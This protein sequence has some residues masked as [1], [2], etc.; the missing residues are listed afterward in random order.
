MAKFRE[1]KL[2]WILVGS[3]L[4]SIGTSFVWP[5]T[6]LYLH[7]TLGKSLTVIGI[8]LL[9]YSG[10]NVVGSYL[11]GL[12]FDKVN[13][14]LLIVGGIFVDVLAMTS[15]VFFNQWPAYPLLL[16]IVGFF[17]GWLTTLINSLGTLIRSKDGRYVFNMLYFASNLGLVIGT[18]IVGF[19][20]HGKVGIMFAITAV[21][22]LLY[23]AVAIKYYFVDTSSIREKGKTRQTKIKIKSANL[24]IMWSLFISLGIIWIMY[25]Q[26]VSNMSVYV[27]GQGVSMPLYSLLWTLN[28][29]LIVVMQMILNWLAHFIKNIFLQIY[30]GIFFCA[31][32]F[33]ILIFSHHYLAFVMAMV[34]LTVGE[35]TAF[36]SI[37]TIINELSPNELKGK[38]QGL[39]N[40]FSSI[41]KALGPLFGG[42]VIEN[43]SYIMLF[44][45]CAAAILLA[46]ILIGVVV[47]LKV[48]DAERY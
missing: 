44:V 14:R 3:F 36:P 5:L 41:G 25:E 34:V 28:A 26:W 18:S 15:L 11:S 8:V 17:N 38:Y 43:S 42:L 47:R 48:D 20:Y 16:S 10:T 31:L 21:L 46:D 29:G 1:I 4:S 2:N 24:W 13:P 39:T 33:V 7:N 19:I 9:M 40:A 35:A 37:P 27:T 22:Y 6:T 30:V 12:L 45:V 32:S 23:L